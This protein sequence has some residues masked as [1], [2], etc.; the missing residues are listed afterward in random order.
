[1]KVVD[2]PGRFASQVARAAGEKIADLWVDIPGSAPLQ[3]TAREGFVK[4]D[5]RTYLAIVEIFPIDGRLSGY[6]AYRSISY[7]FSRQNRER[8]GRIARE[9]LAAEYSIKTNEVSLKLARS[10]FG[11][12]H[13]DASAHPTPPLRAITCTIRACSL[14]YQLSRNYQADTLTTEGSPDGYGQQLVVWAVS[15][16]FDTQRRSAR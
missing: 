4:F 12:P 14:A 3:G 15:R 2:Q 13:P 9:V 7:V 5:D 10:H 11:R 16:L 6:D 1:M 8:V